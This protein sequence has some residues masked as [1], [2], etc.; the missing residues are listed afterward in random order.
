MSKD[1]FA[2]VVPE[3]ESV[4][5]VVGKTANGSRAVQVVVDGNVVLAVN[6]VKG[7]VEFET[8]NVKIAG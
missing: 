8:G 1:T 4:T 3:A 2:I 5:V 7:L 6:R